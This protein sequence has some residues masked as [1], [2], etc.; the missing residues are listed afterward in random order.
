MSSWCLGETADN[1]MLDDDHYLNMNCR[2][3]TI[4][5]LLWKILSYLDEELGAV[6]YLGGVPVILIGQ[7]YIRFSP[8]ELATWIYR[9]VS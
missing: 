5:Q 1:V 6:L 4:E 9:Y 2:K 3:D 7:A 8:A